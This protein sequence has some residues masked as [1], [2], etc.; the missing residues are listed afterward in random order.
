MNDSIPL[1]G[2]RHD[3]FGHHLKAW[4]ILRALHQCADPDHCDTEAE[5]WWDLDEACF[6]IRSPK[7]DSLEKLAEFFAT[8]YKPTVMLTPWDKDIGYKQGVEPRPSKE[9][10]QLAKTLSGRIPKS[11]GGIIKRA[12]FVEY[13]DGA[14][15]VDGSDMDAIA[16]PFVGRSSDN[17]VFLNRGAAGRAQMFRTYWD[18]V[19]QIQKERSK[20]NGGKLPSIAEKSF[21]GSASQTGTKKGKGAPFFPDAIKTYNNGSGWVV[22]SYPFNAL[23]YI[24]AV[25]GA[26]ALRG[27]ASRTLAANSRRFAAFPFVFETG[28]DMTDDSGD[29]KDTAKALWLPLWDRPVS[30]S[31]LSSFVCDAQARLPGKEAKYSS[32]FARALRSQG[33]D[34]GFAA[35]QEFRYKMKASR[36]PWV[37]TGSYIGKATTDRPLLLTDALEPLDD[38]AF[39]DQFRE[40]WKGAKIEASSPHHY[41]EAIN[42]A[43]ECAARS[44]TRENA[45]EILLEIFTAT[46]QLSVSKSLRGKTHGAR[47]FQPLP[48]NPWD[49]L[50]DGLESSQEFLIA[51]A[52]ASMTGWEK[53]PDGR[54]SE[55]QPMLGSILPLN[56]GPSGWYLS[57][58]SHQAVWTGFDLYHDL[59]LI[60]QRRYLDSLSDR[61]PALRSVHPAPLSAILAFLRGELDLQQIARWAEALSL[62]GWHR[63]KTKNQLEDKKTEESDTDAPIWQPEAISPA[64]AALR[65]LLEVE[66]EWQGTEDSLWQKRRSRIPF[67]LLCQRSSETVTRAVS[68]SLHRLSIW[69]V[70]NP[71]RNSREESPRL[72]GKTVI[73]PPRINVSPEEASRLAAAVC[74][75][76][77]WK[78]QLQLYQEIT[79]PAKTQT[80]EPAL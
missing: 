45:L 79:I 25:E 17:P 13:R 33:A 76:L 8:H 11:N 57:E 19:E 73:K 36:I 22:E 40:S 67:A 56:L 5:A 55:V 6:H 7:Y 52:L 70:R 9:D 14:V 18:Y 39:L 64:Y 10:V 27:S 16:A 53:Q 48:M 26:L 54:R 34:V 30:Y 59:A 23:D 78:N 38:A 43:I 2:C 61:L 15:S 62:I 50:L 77:E 58:R 20:S 4:G 42:A 3:I 74:I 66:C 71:D 44:P 28:E 41:R 60:L 63:T 1:P 29:I 49:K 65:S 75:P 68:E 72:Q 12:N 80:K 35:W 31:E 21:L 47:F 32:E 46:K 37:C 24:L 51:R 69:G